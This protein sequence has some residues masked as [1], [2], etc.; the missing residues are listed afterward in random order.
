MGEGLGIGIDWIKSSKSSV[1]HFSRPGL[2]NEKMV[3]V[4]EA[5]WLAL[6]DPAGV[7]NSMIELCGSQKGL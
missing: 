2:L 6:A 1:A 7:W 3:S 5:L 4:K